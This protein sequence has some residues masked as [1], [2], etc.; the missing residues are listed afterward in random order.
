MNRRVGTKRQHDL[1][2]VGLSLMV[3]A[4]LAAS[5]V[6]FA[7]WTHEVPNAGMA[8][9]L[10]DLD[11]EQNIPT[12]F[13]T[14]LLAYLALGAWRL[15]PSF[16]STTGRL[17]GLAFGAGILLLSADEAAMLHERIA[18]SL[19]G[20][21]ASIG[22]GWV[23][24]W[25]PIAIVTRSIL[26]AALWICSRRLVLGLVGGAMV[27]LSGA[28]GLET[29]GQSVRRETVDQIRAGERENIGRSYDIG[30]NRI[31]K[32]TPAYLL[33]ST[34]EEGLELAGIVVWAAVVRRARRDAMARPNDRSPVTPT[35]TLV[36]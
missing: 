12:W 32:D 1:I 21:F 14:V 19:A 6:A 17:A 28:V 25:A 18:G 10:F 9:L 8:M 24:Y 29:G 33:V 7:M 30:C 16:A 34:G 23:A 15:T 26:G 3:A 5:L 22:S 4:L 31:G 2:V 11:Q 35:A 36:A 13:S 20:D 27:H